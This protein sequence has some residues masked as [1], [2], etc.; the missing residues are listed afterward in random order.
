MDVKLRKVGNSFVVTI[1]L[2][3]VQ[4]LNIH[5]GDSLTMKDIGEGILCEKKKQ[6]TTIDW[7][8]YT[9]FNNSK[10]ATNPVS[11]VREL[12]ENDRI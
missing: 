12:R 3:I 9:N 7:D 8:K 10:R 1:P 11:Y 4:R 5:V 2:E 6:S